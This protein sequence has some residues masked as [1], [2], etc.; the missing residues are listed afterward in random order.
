M[1]PGPTRP[2]VHYSVGWRIQTYTEPVPLKYGTLATNYPLIYGHF[3]QCSK[4]ADSWLGLL[5]RRF[6]GAIHKH[7]DCAEAPAP[8]L[9]RCVCPSVRPS[10]SRTVMTRRHCD[11]RQQQ[12]QQQFHVDGGGDDETTA[13]VIHAEWLTCVEPVS[14]DPLICLRRLAHVSSVWMMS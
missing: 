1:K 10:V 5:V 9:A 8:A 14:T 12:Q 6:R 7:I 11:R 13:C 2:L 3:L 4:D